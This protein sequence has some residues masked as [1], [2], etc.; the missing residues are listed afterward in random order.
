MP[1]TQ[2]ALKRLQALVCAEICAVTTQLRLEMRVAA[3]AYRVHPAAA[4][5]LRSF[6]RARQAALAA[7]TAGSSC[8]DYLGGAWETRTPSL[9]SWLNRAVEGLRHHFEG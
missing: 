5:L 9:P 2:S 7:G 8:M 1:M 4:E 6:A 3:A